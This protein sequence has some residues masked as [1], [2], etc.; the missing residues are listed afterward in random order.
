MKSIRYPAVAGMFYDS[1]KAGLETQIRNAFF[2]RCGP[3]CLHKN[4][5][6]IIGIV[7]PHAGYEYSGHVAAHAYSCLPKNSAKNFI[8]IGPNHTGIGPN[9]SVWSRGKWLTPLGEAKI[10]EKIAD[11]IISS[12]IAEEDE[13]AHLN[14]HSIEVQIPFLQFLFGNIDFVPVCMKDQSQQAAKNIANAVLGIKEDV[15][16]IASS[17][18]TH[19]ES[20]ESAERKDADAIRAIES[21]DLKKFYRVIEE[22]RISICGFG[23]I[24]VLMLIVKKRGG[25]IMQI[26]HSTSWDITGDLSNVVGYAALMGVK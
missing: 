12:S 21:M 13:S 24:A 10:N 23:A 25:K 14:E 17:D 1:R 22:E 16:L 18:F 9:V 2:H 3:G 7:V 8:I 15:I 5:E 26:A 19:F 11:K 4:D 6:N 20:K